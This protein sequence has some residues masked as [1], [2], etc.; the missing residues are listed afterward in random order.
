MIKSKRALLAAL[1]ATP[2]LG[3][4]PAKAG[5]YEGDYSQKV[6]YHINDSENAMA[7]LRNVR[8][9]LDADPKSKIV[10]V[11]HGKGIDFLLEGAEDKNKNP[12][13]VTVQTL[14]ER[15]VEFK[16]CNNTLVAR[17]ID[18][19]KVIPE[20]DIVPSGVAEIG[21]LQAKYGFVYLKP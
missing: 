2:L 10:V 19:S 3:V 11:T 15:G 18:K 7:A 21:L 14:K 17:K 4:V 1:A 6:V 12:Y 5:G 8:N 20:A 13:Q 9:H 16:V